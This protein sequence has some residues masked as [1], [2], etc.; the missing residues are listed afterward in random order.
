MTYWAGG[1]SSRQRW[2][3]LKSLVFPGVSRITRGL[4]AASVTRWILVVLPPTLSQW[5]DA[6]PPFS[7][8]RTAMCSDD[9]RIDHQPIGRVLAAAQH[10]KDPFPD[11]AFGPA[12]EAI[13][14]GLG[15]PILPRTMRPVTARAQNMHDAAQ[16]TTVINAL[17]APRVGRQ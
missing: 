3:G 4:P 15:R 14:D 5:P 7:A 17:Q 16:D 6:G 13:V 10:R 8:S 2:A 1:M 12:H 11:P 9:C